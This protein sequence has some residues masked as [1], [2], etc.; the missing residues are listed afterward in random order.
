MPEHYSFDKRD[1]ALLT[2]AAALLKKVAS[3]ETLH[4]AELVSVAKLQ[5]VLS[6]LPRVA[7]NLEVTVSVV[8]P[9]RKFGEIETWHYWEIGIEGKQL[10]ISSGGHFYQPSTG[11]DSFTTM[12]WTAVPEEP[13]ELGDYRATL[14]MVPDVQSFPEAVAGIEFA[15][16]A[17]RIEITDSENSLLEEDEDTDVDPLQQTL[18]EV[19]SDTAHYCQEICGPHLEDQ[20]PVLHSPLTQDTTYRLSPGAGDYLLWVRCSDPWGSRPEFTIVDFWEF[21]EGDRLLITNREEDYPAAVE[22]MEEGGP[23]VWKALPGDRLTWV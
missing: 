21:R 3:A 15:S 22:Q 2:A 8:G 1:R 11:G 6:I 18:C 10:S 20:Q 17:Y 5:H 23:S 14:E 9:R 16:G 12:N 7:H 4:P 19:E 13:A